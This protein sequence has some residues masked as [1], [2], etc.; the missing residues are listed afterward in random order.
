MAEPEI[1]AASSEHGFRSSKGIQY[2]G[3]DLYPMGGRGH[4]SVGPLP[5]R[6]TTMPLLSISYSSHSVLSTVPAPLPA[7]RADQLRSGAYGTCLS[8]RVC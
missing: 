7:L 8:T 6:P 4:T 3:D 1:A 2:G 5:I